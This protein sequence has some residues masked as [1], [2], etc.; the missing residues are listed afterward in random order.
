MHPSTEGRPVPVNSIKRCYG[1]IEKRH[2]K[3]AGKALDPCQGMALPHR[4]DGL[5]GNVSSSLRSRTRI[6]SQRASIRP[7]S[8]RPPTSCLPIQRVQAIFC[9]PDIVSGQV[10]LI[11]PDTDAEA[12]CLVR[13]L[14]RQ[15]AATATQPRQ[16][17]P[18]NLPLGIRERYE[19]WIEEPRERTA[20]KAPQWPSTQLHEY[21]AIDTNADMFWL[22]CRHASNVGRWVRSGCLAKGL[23]VSETIELP[24]MLPQSLRTGHLVV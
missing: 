1:Q 18:C 13:N 5:N 21:S 19:N 15:E 6:P 2:C 10:S 23:E 9:H 8:L 20:R 14:S 16:S 11:H 4:P 24:L 12:K 17:A 3:Y 22:R 7:L